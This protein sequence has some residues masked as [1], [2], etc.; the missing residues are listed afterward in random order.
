MHMADMYAALLFVGLAMAI[1]GLLL[2]VV[3][4][5]RSGGKAEGGAVLLLGP[6]PIVFGS[7]PRIAL[8]LMAMA[9]AVM[10]MYLAVAFI[11]AS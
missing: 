6:I 11:W 2:L 8:L 9:I 10:A 5:A 3:L 4:S 7:S 1:I